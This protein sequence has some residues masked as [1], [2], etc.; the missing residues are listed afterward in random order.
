MILKM[1]SPSGKQPT[2]QESSTRTRRSRGSDE[3]DDHQT[4]ALRPN[5]VVLSTA[6]ANGTFS[7]AWLQFLDE[8]DSERSSFSTQGQPL[9]ASF[10]MEQE[11][12][13]RSQDSLGTLLSVLD[14]AMAILEEEEEDD[15][16]MSPIATSSL[17]PEEDLSGTSPSRFEQ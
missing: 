6:D 2:I 3:G 13:E 12:G 14:E 5:N 8:R 11:Q 4:V 16:M 17:H 15:V 7:H 10:V 9:F 1:K